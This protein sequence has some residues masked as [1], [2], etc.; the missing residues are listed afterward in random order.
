[1]PEGPS[2]SGDAGSEPDSGGAPPETAGG[3]EG[4]YAT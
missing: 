3:E 1:M 4:K 2:R